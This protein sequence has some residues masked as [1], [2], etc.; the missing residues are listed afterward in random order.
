MSAAAPSVSVVIPTFERRQSVTEAVFS[1]LNQT[2]GDLEVIVVDDGSTDGTAAAVRAIDQ[3]VKVVRRPNGGPAAARNTGIR[4]ARAPLLAFLDSDDRWHR[5]HL[6][7]LL[8]LFDSHPAA[9]LACTGGATFGDDSLRRETGH[10]Q[11]AP[12]ILLGG[13]VYTSAVGVTR[14]AVEAVGGFDEELRVLE[15]ADL[16]CRL[17]L[18]GPFVLGGVP[19]VQTGRQPGSLREQG[20]LAGLY[21]PAHERSAGQFVQRASETADRRPLTESRRLARAGRGTAAA[22]RAMSALIAGERRRAKGELAS[23]CRQFPELAERP[24]LFVRRI[25]R[26]H[27]R[28]HEPAERERTLAW[29]AAVWPAVTA[30]R[31]DQRAKRTS[32][33]SAA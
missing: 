9:V 18:E 3:R 27:P 13:L 31:E 19:T 23:A 11:V 28:W 12:A 30:P 16:W 10:R 1:V 8:G 17:S 5:R 25:G 21:P 32:G 26:S 7:E 22:A 20:R 14:E 15:D 24:D 4:H 29:L 6:E 33:T 2:R